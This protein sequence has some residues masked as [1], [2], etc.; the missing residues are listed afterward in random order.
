MKK[1]KCQEK[2]GEVCKEVDGKLVCEKKKFKI[3]K[4]DG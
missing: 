3:C 2:E 4:E 1:V